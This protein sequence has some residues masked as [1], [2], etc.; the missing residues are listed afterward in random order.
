MRPSLVPALLLV[1]GSLALPAQDASKAQ[2]QL[3]FVVIPVPLGSACPVGMY[4]RHESGLHARVQVNGK[5]T[6]DTPGLPFVLTLTDP[7]PGQITKA[8]VTIHGVSGKWQFIPTNT[9]RDGSADVTKTINLVFAGGDE[10]KSASAALIAPGFTSVNS[11]VLDSVTYANGS[12]WK[13]S[14][15]NACQVAPDPFVLIDAKMAH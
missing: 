7:R 14:S 11:I 4:A 9:A 3:N 1:L 6:A 2:K 10:E 5:A 12:T 13:F 8:T 15:T